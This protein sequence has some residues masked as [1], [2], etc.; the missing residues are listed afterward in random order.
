MHTTSVVWA[1]I[2]LVSLCAIGVLKESISRAQRR[3]SSITGQHLHHVLGRMLL[4][5]VCLGTVLCVLQMVMDSVR[6]QI[7]HPLSWLSIPSNL[8]ELLWWV[9]LNVV[10]FLV[11]GLVLV[12]VMDSAKQSGD[13]VV[14][15]SGFY[16]LLL[17]LVSGPDLSTGYLV[18]VGVAA[19]ACWSLLEYIVHKL[20]LLPYASGL[21]RSNSSLGHSTNR[22]PRGVF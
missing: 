20:E 11:T 1:T 6:R 19:A 10:S 3:T 5:V 18:G 12:G 8:T 9:G 22:K 17:G 21:S 14:S 7:I 16:I 13:Y 2:I 15:L 4:A